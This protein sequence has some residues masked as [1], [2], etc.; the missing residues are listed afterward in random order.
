MKNISN[1]WNN[2]T[3]DKDKYQKQANQLMEKYNIELKEWEKNM[4]ET[5]HSDFLKFNTKSEHDYSTD[6]NKK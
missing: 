1:E 4:I 3:E 2:T 6:K 5:G